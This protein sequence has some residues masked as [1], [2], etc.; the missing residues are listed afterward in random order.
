[1]TQLELNGV[2]PPPSQPQLLEIQVQQ[3]ASPQAW[4]I[5]LLCLLML[6]A[7]LYGLGWYGGGKASRAQLK[8]AKQQHKQQIDLLAEQGEALKAQ[9]KAQTE[10][11]R[12]QAKTQRKADADFRAGVD[13]TLGLMQRESAAHSKYLLAT[14]ASAA[15][16]GAAAEKLFGECSRAFAEMA[17][18]A[19]THATDLREHREAWPRPQ[20]K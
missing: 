8:E 6:S 1:M 14:A 16:R 15:A 4:L 19:Q 18:R 2:P 11:A 13:R 17:G 9:H 12:E 3:P 5:A 10:Q 7:G 20:T